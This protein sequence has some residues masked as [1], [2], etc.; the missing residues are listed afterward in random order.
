MLSGDP[1]GEIF[2]SLPRP[3]LYGILTGIALAHFS[4]VAAPQLEWID[5][6]EHGPRWVDFAKYSRAVIVLMPAPA[7][8]LVFAVYLVFSVVA[9]FRGPRK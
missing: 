7:G 5:A 2:R 8:V 6:T 9:A 1:L 4:G 3:I